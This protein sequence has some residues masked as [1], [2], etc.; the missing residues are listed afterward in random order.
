MVGISSTFLWTLSYLPSPISYTTTCDS[1]GC[2]AFSIHMLISILTTQYACLCK[3]A[4][5]CVCAFMCV[6]QTV[7]I[8][9]HH[10]FRYRFLLICKKAAAVAAACRRCRILFLPSRVLAL[11]TEGPFLVIKLPLSISLLLP[12]LFFS[13]V[14][15]FVKVEYSVCLP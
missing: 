12:L 3:R 10:L 1:V 2:L 11:T 7:R 9:T 15:Q 14:C 13:S 4:C 5:V 6:Y 8:L